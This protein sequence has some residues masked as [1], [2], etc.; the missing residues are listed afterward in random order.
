MNKKTQIK[1]LAVMA[2]LL[3][4]YYFMNTFLRL[5]DK[6]SLVSSLETDINTTRD[7]ITKTKKAHEKLS[8]YDENF[9]ENAYFDKEEYFENYIRDLLDKYNITVTNYQ[10]SKNEEKY[11]EVSLKFDIYTMDLFKLIKDFEQG[12]KLIII[13]NISVKTSAPPYLSIFMKIRGHYR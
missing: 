1:I 3:T 2:V 11:G 10:S 5:S 8:K 12:E 7:K 6:K 13:K 4:A 9:L